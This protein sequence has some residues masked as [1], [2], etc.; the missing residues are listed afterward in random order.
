LAGL[1]SASQVVFWFG[2]QENVLI[3]ALI[4]GPKS[5]VWVAGLVP[6]IRMNIEMSLAL[7]SPSGQSLFPPDYPFP[8]STPEKF[9]AK[10]LER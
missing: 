4:C 8:T 1:F 3:R 5:P 2:K 10:K 9:F 7:F 6:R